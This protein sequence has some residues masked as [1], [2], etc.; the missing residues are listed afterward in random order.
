MIKA[1]IKQQMKL[2][3][4]KITEEKTGDINYAQV[5]ANGIN[6]LKPAAAAD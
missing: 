1:W 5:N 3:K 6:N 4:F 2:E